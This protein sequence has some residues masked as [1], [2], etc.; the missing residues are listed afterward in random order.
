MLSYGVAAEIDHAF[1]RRRIDVVRSGQTVIIV[2]FCS[3]IH[4]NLP[5]LLSHWYQRNDPLDAAIEISSFV[6]GVLWA[7]VGGVVGDD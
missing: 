3:L 7:V 6:L 1:D 4:L 2:H 5:V